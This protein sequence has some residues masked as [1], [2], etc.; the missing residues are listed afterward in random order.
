MQLRSLALLAS[1]IGAGAL[2]S[3]GAFAAAPAPSLTKCEVFPGD[4]QL[5][6][7]Q[8]RQSLVVLASYSNG[9]TR[10]VLLSGRY[11]FEVTTTRVPAELFLDPL[12]DPTMS[13]I[14]S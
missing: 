2:P 9:V 12:Y 7:K 4:V 3:T 1:I 5:S 13:R 6:A 11:E 14:K 10:D 8:E